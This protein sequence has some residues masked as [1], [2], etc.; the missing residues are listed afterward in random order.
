MQCR[1]RNACGQLYCT[2]VQCTRHDEAKV[3][4]IYI[5]NASNT[6]YFLKRKLTGLQP[7]PSCH[8]ALCKLF[9]R[10]PAG[11]VNFVLEGS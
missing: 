6:N 4:M 3:F 2:G 11:E 5:D 1:H 9:S 8:K 10:L 7:T